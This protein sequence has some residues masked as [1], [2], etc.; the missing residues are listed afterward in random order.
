MVIKIF[1]LLVLSIVLTACNPD[2]KRPFVYDD[3]VKVIVGFYAGREGTI[4][5]EL[6]DSCKYTVQFKDSYRVDDIK[7]EYLHI[8]N[9]GD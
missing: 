8:I 7:E 6:K 2:C 9:Q 5:S 1:R 4:L 3:K